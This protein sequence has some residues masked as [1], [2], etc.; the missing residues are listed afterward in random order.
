MDAISYHLY[1]GINQVG[2]DNKRSGSNVLAIM[3]LIESYSYSNW[4][5][6][7]P[8]AITEYGGIAVKVF[9]DQKCTV[10]KITKCHDF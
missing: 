8:H 4:G 1:D 7:K 6:I 5:F 3:D 10:Y 2:Q 9:N